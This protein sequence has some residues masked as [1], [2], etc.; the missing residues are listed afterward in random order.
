M[1]CSKTISQV[2]YRL[3]YRKWL[4]WSM[5]IIKKS[6]KESRGVRRSQEESRR[7]RRSREESRGIRRNREESRGIRRNQW[8]AMVWLASLVLQL[9]IKGTIVHLSWDF[10]SLASNNK[11]NKVVKI[12]QSFLI[13]TYQLLHFII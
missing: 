2:N 4:I 1:R 11:N 5:I 10:S 6:Q 12:N 7:V 8:F 13:W 3:F 9:Y